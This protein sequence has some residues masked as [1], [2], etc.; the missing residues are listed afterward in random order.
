VETIRLRQ[1]AD[2]YDVWPLEGTPTHYRIGNRR[3]IGWVRAD[4]VLPWDTRLV[5]RAPGG[6]VAAAPAPAG[7]GRSAV[8]VGDIPSPVIAWK[9]GAIAVAL[10][11]ARRPWE[12]VARSGWLRSDDLPGD[13]WGVLLSEFEV[14]ALLDEPP[15]A[16]TPAGAGL[17]RLRAVLGR[18]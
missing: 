18:L 17:V 16:M 5:L 1:F 10:W 3:P 2:V 14:R 7:A 13:A 4:A 8:E 11:D 12:R 9:P 6:K 15:M